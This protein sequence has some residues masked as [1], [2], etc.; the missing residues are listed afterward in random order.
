MSKPRK[1]TDTGRTPMDAALRYLGAR[2]RTVREVER[3]LDACE[4]GEVEVYETVERLRE[5][6]LLDDLA[7]ANEFVRTRLAT[8]PVSRA[9]LREQLLTH[10]VEESAMEQALMQIDEEAQQRSAVSVAEKYARQYAHLSSEERDEMVLRRL[11]SRGYSYDDA[12]AA[13][14]EAT[15]EKTE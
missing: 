10:E 14:C 12:R 7:F 6:G 2:A 1:A 9:H 11:L 13:L 8:K 15:G 4:Y 3:H 5:L